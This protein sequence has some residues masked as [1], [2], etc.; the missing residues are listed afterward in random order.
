MSFNYVINLQ[1]SFITS[2]KTLSAIFAP[3]KNKRAGEWAK[4]KV[5]MPHVPPRQQQQ[6]EKCAGVR[7]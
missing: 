3:K 5:N 7:N 4:A 2:V 6:N 1:T